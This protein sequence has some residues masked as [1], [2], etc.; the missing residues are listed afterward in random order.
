MKKFL[1]GAVGLIA[2][3]M[4]APAVAADLAAAPYSKAPPTMMAAVYDWSGLYIGIDGGWGSSHKCWDVT[5]V[6]AGPDG[7]HNATG[8]V[9]GGQ[10][11]YRLQSGGW[12]YGVEVQGDWADLRGSNVS[13]QT[14][15]FTNRSRIDAFGL[16]TGQIGYA[17]NTV[18]L[19]A[20]GGGALAADRFDVISTP[21]GALAATTTNQVRWGGTVGAGVEFAFAPNWSIAA[22][23]DHLFMGSK[24]SAFVATIGGLFGT[25]R[26][27]QDADLVTARVN[28]RLGGPV[29]S[30]Y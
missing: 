5:G 27:R 8:G 13:L 3:G 6:F 2:L 22:E 9:A 17:I 30:K 19:Y 15:A 20:K 12:V 21:S 18:L 28:Y 24:D 11:G 1:L 16:F 7:C 4:A 23:Y 14:P 10:M 26:I 25:E 29:I